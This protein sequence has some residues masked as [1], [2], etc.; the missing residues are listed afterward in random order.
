MGE[1]PLPARGESQLL[2]SVHFGKKILPPL[3][4]RKFGTMEVGPGTGSPG[5]KGLLGHIDL[6]FSLLLRFILSWGLSLITAADV[7]HAGLWRA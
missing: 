6:R 4:V 2:L 3:I 7:Y 1:A 5:G